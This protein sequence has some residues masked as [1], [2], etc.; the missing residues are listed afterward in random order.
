MLGLDEAIMWVRTESGLQYAA[1]W[2]LREG[3]WQ[4]VGSEGYRFEW[5][6]GQPLH[7]VIKAL[8]LSNRT[9][10]WDDDDDPDFL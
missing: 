4:F 9:Y 7:T 1:L 6:R 2:R 10:R 3:T 5:M 8:G